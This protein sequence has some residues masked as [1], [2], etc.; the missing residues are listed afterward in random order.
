MYKYV[1]I[2][3]I[4]DDDNEVEIAS[5]AGACP[6]K[7]ALKWPERETVMYVVNDDVQARLPI[8]SSGCD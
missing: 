3:L 6:R 1:A 7:K 4:D 8:V 5:L 2:N